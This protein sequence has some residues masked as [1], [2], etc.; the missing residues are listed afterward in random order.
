MIEGVQTREENGK[1]IVDIAAQHIDFR[2]AQ[3][4][5]SFVANLYEA[6]HRYVLLNLGQVGFMDSSGLS[7]LLIGQRS[8]DEHQGTF[9][10]YGVQG[11]VNNLIEL[12]HLNRVIPICQTEQEALEK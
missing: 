6:G 4:L 2:N 12:T 8:A 1:T 7:V 5:K 11:Y 9:A 3:Q 10:V